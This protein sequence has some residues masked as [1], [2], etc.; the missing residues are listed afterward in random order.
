M[1][2]LNDSGAPEQVNG[3]FYREWMCDTD[4]LNIMANTEDAYSSSYDE[5]SGISIEIRDS[6]T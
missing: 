2:T 6:N 4:E 3:G 1:L 5:V